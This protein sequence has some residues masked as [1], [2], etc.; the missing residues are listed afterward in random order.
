VRTRHPYGWELAIVAVTVAWGATF[1]L[2]QRAVEHVP[3]MHFLALR[4]AIAA[5]LLAIVRPGD[6]RRLTRV[7]LRA[8]AAAGVFLFVSY[9]SQT[10]GLQFTSSSNVGFITGLYVVMVP[11]LAAVV[12][13]R[14]PSRASLIA[15]ALATAGLFLLANPSSGGFGRGEV[16]ALL[17]AASFAVQILIVDRVAS[18]VSLVPFTVVQLGAVAVC[19]AIGAP[20]AGGPVDLSAGVVW[21]AIG[22]T[23]V[24]A[25]ALGYLVQAA[26]QRRVPP[27]RSA[28]LFAMESPF[29][30]V[31]GWLLAG[32]RIGA[33]G[34]IGGALMVAGVVVTE[35]KAPARE[36]A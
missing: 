29:A 33:A 31:F 18:R 1:V 20:F 30:A 7:D 36:D 32:D 27:T 13:R 10:A 24:F 3:V 22:F 23:A 9:A 35:T 4:F 2:V 5:V 26:A 15:V 28:I 14:L 8:G 25:S 17:C 6:V 16:F 11:L 34:W 19:S 12:F 21:E